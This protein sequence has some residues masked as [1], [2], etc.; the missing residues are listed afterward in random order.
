MT[1][2]RAR[3]APPASGMTSARD[4][5]RVPPSR[6]R[7]QA[8]VDIGSSAVDYDVGTFGASSVNAAGVDNVGRVTAPRLLDLRAIADMLGLAD[9]TVRNY[10][11]TAERRR[12]QGGSRPGDFPAP[13]MRFGLVPVWK[14]STIRSWKKRRPGRGAGG[15]RPRKEVAE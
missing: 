12:R 3:I 4:S 13:D 8:T 10:H 1:A 9:R 2:S 11:Q 15:G 6:G 7:R 14:A 5:S